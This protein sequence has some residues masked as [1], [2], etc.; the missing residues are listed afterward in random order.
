MSNFVHSKMEL[1]ISCKYHE[2]S[3]MFGIWFT[4]PDKLK[5]FLTPT[6]QKYYSLEGITQSHT[7]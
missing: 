4:L 1:L 5:G 7:Q 6:A 3:N 2:K